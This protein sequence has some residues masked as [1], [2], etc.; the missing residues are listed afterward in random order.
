MQKVCKIKISKKL[1]R[2]TWKN[3]KTEYDTLWLSDLFKASNIKIL[4]FSLGAGVWL[5][6][7]TEL[8]TLTKE[9]RYSLNGYS[10]FFLIKKTNIK[11]PLYT[12][13]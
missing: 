2:I 4:T 10:V 11:K 1:N 7:Y 13:L 12:A 5:Y 6:D 9:I 3:K 8:P